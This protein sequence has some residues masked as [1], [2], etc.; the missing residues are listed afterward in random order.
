MTEKRQLKGLHS[1]SVFIF[2][3]PFVA[4]IGDL[5]KKGGERTIFDKTK[6]GLG[7]SEVDVFVDA[8]FNLAS[9]KNC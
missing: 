2:N 6:C 5:Q 1:T 7:G 3:A 4:L 9:E 8:F